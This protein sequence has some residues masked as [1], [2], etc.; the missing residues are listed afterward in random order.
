MGRWGGPLSRAGGRFAVA[1]V[2]RAG[3]VKRQRRGPVPPFAGL[4]GARRCRRRGELPREGGRVAARQRCGSTGRWGSPLSRARGRFAVAG[5]S[6]AKLVKCQRSGPVPPV[7][8]LVGGGGAA[9][10]GSRGALPRE[11]GRVAARQRC[12]TLRHWGRPLSTA[13]G[14]FAVAGLVK[15]QRSGSVPPVAGLVKGVN[16]GALSCASLRNA[17]THSPSPDTS[18]RRRCRRGGGR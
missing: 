3:P 4:V 10:A 1:G 2:S 13:R 15:R 12:G 5:A 16:G 7:A 14:R 8:G 11:I 18:L 17:P 9:G 6:R